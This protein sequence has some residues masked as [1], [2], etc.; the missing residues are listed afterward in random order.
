MKNDDAELIQRTL[1]GDNNAFSELV[2]KYQKQVHALAWRKIGDFHTAEDITQDTFL[3]AYQRLHTLKEPHRF[4][5]WLYV[6]ASRR[7]LAWFRKKRLQKQV[8]ENIGTP[9]TNRDA[10]SRHVAEEQAKTIDEAQQEVVKKLL[11]TLKESDRIVITLHY[12][13]EMTCEEMSEFLGVSANTIKSRLRRARNRLKKEEPM[14]REAISNFQI[15]PNLTNNIMQEVAR[16]KPAAPSG[17]KP[18]IPWVIGAAGTVLIA[19]MFGIGG[20]YLA[21]FQ[22]PYSLDAQTEMTVELVDAPIVQNLDMQPD[23]RRELGNLNALG[24]SDNRGEK[25]DEGL[26]SAA[27]VEGEDMSNQKQQWI[28]AKRVKGAPAWNLYAT[29]EGELYVMTNYFSVYKLSADG[30]TWQHVRGIEKLKTS[31]GGRLPITK[32]NNTLYLVPYNELFTS[33]DNGETWDLLYS[34]KGEKYRS[35][36]KLA[37]TEQAFYL[38]FQSGVLRSED[39]GKTWEDIS[40]E[41]TVRI[42]SFIEIQNT[43]FAGTP[44]GCYRYS[45]DSWKRLEFPVP[46]QRV[47]STAS[48]DG[49]LYV[50]A[51]WGWAVSKELKRTWGIFRSTDLGDSWQDITPTNS[52]HLNGHPP[53]ITLI[54]AGET[55]LAMEQGMVRSIDGGDTWLSPQAYNASPPMSN[56]SSFAVVK[57]DTIYIGSHDGLY[58]SNNRGESWHKM[59]IRQK[60]GDIFNLITF[61][62]TGKAKSPSAVI[63]ARV[64][65]GTISGNEIQKTDDGGNS[66]E[67]VQI[68]IPM[69]DP[70]RRTPPSI[71]QIVKYGGLLYAKGK[72]FV[73]RETLIYRVSGDGRTLV[74]IQ[75]MPVFSSEKLDDQIPKGHALG[76]TQ[77]FKQLAEPKLMAGPKLFGKGE[78]LIQAGL[79]G[80]FAVDN[81]TFYVEYNFKLFRWE[82]GDTEWYDTGLEETIE[83][84]AS[85]RQS[86]VWRDIDRFKLAVSGNTVYVGKRDGH[87]VVSFDR[88]TNWIDLTP[89]LPFP[90]KTFKEIL[91]AGST[92]YVATDGGIITSDEGRHWRT[93]IG[94]DGT[95]LIMERLAVDGAMLYGVTK[96]TG[97]YRLE[98]GTWEHV[99]SEIPDRVTSLAVDGDTLYVGTEDNGMLHFSLEE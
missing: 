39:T 57:K 30:K 49:K 47:V 42:D 65:G 60:G 4:A 19:L 10:Y 13:G 45:G 25:P 36:I 7:C 90:V 14:I 23:V 32:W 76:A 5:G 51:G 93:V 40:D 1:A 58:S 21:R 89:A 77:F 17:S 61:K 26:L 54:A 97:I 31:S 63:Y 67:P 34:W 24:E 94:S 80:A 8:L 71:T 87:L 66:W 72:K 86:V 85:R 16:L 83:L 18:L 27:Q 92:V 3:K 68:A 35:A 50:V 28:H 15:S 81:D 55:L 46:I 53:N 91:V 6:I 96:D 33:T 59:N 99:V 64:D 2:E 79:R 98:N 29:P 44:N 88:G 22:Q 74:P 62:K 20:Q 37:P 41:L 69:T 52:W 70:H 43:L 11:E 82:P 84:S 73:P 9:V 95:N 78:D 12:F 38:A 56:L 75:G 48:T